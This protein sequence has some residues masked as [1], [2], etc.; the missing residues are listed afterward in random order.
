MPRGGKKEKRAITWQ[1]AAEIARALPG[2][3]EG[4]SYG[5]PAFK[6]RGKLFVR[7]HQSG[8]AVV[9]RVDP[10]E[11]AMRMQADPRAFFITDHYLKYPMWMLVR[12]SA[13]RRADLADLIE[14]AWRLQAPGRL[15]K[16]ES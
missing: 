2:A 8:E 3:E 7:F 9:V 4:T 12:L 10:A 1:T 5:T 13:V 15:L 14:E 11:R 16:P 6:V